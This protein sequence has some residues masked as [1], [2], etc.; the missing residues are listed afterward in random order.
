[1]VLMSVIP[2]ERRLLLSADWKSEDNAITQDSPGVNPNTPNIH[3]RPSC[4]ETSMDPSDQGESSDQSHT[5][6]ANVHLGSHTADRPTDPSDPKESS[7]PHEGAHEGTIYSHVQSVGN[8]SLRKESLL[9]TSEFTRV[10]VLIHVQSAGNVL[11][12]KERL[13]NTRE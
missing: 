7:A 13:L 12:R 11:L 2:R 9:S 10:N 3:H 4:P 1:M 8:V 5:R 6:S